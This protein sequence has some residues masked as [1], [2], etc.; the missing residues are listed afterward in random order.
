MVNKDFP[1]KAAIITKDSVITYHQLG[2]H[3]HQ[4]SQFIG[5]REIK[6]IAIFSEN[7]PE[8]IYAFYA[9]WENGCIAVPVDFMAS[10]DD[11]AYIIN[12]C[13]PE[14]IFGSAGTKDSLDKIQQK[15]SYQPEIQI[16]DEVNLPAFTDADHWEGP[17]DR[18]TTAVIIYTSGTTGSPKGVM[19]SF[20]NL[21]AN[22]TA[23]TKEVAI[24][25]P[26]RQV[27]LLLPLH[28]VF[29]LVGSMV[30]PLH[31]GA[32]AV[33]SP[34]MQTADLM[35]TF[36]KNQVAIMIGVP[37]LYELMFKGISTKI[38][39]SIVA[40][41]LFAIVR[42]FHSKK[43]SRK[44]FK[45]VHDGLGGHLEIMVAGGAALNKEVGQFWKDLGFEIL[46]GFGMTEAA[47]M[48]TFTRPGRLRIGS[49]G[50][51][52]PSMRIEIRDGE[53]VAKGPNVMQGYYN[54]PEE[55][56]EVIKDGWLH[57]GDLGYID[58]KG[59]LFITGRKKEIIVLSNGK[60]IN[61]LELEYKLEKASDCIR[62][63]GVFIKNEQL[64]ALIVPNFQLL[65]EKEIKDV[66]AYFRNEVFPPFNQEQSSYKRI[67]QFTIVRDDLPR[68]RLGKMQ[69]FKLAELVEKPKPGAKKVDQ[70]DMPEYLAVKSFLESQVDID[71]APNQHIE[72]DIALDSL[73]KI[74]LIDYIEQTFGV[75]IE[76]KQ[77]IQF[78][79]LKH[80]AEYIRDKKQWIKEG[81]A[82]WS[83]ALKEKVEVKLPKTWFT[84]NILKGFFKGL[85]SIYFKMQS[86][87]V[88]NVP[89]TGPYIIAPNHQS[90]F[91]G[92]FVAILLKRNIMHN[93]YFYAK[94]KHV[95]NFILRF[96]ANT[97]NVIVMDTDRDLK[98]SI[99]KLAEVLKQG[100]N[101]IIFPEGTRT[102]NGAIGEFKKTFAILSTELNVP[103]IPVA[104]D[105][106][107]KAMPQG[108][109]LPKAGTKISVTF[110]PAI[111]PQDHTADT[112]ADAVQAAILETM[113]N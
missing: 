9:A 26:D 86:K 1:N 91:D 50:E 37:R 43:L 102:T 110:L 58:K 51:A 47:P 66:D 85:F 103:V 84:Q 109:K 59:Y 62:E 46:E 99:Q 6:K 12:D 48:I 94:R 16:F 2:G 39:S 15:L 14:I 96:L 55:T 42:R 40:R 64:H 27:L 35:E 38:N 21:D 30:V 4:Y 81:T 41:T 71:I 101:I 68:T 74:S 75:A 107:F 17:S 31:I 32:T 54:R 90:F 92:L 80:M 23:V 49:P 78:P 18:E 76:E 8:W 113:P 105:G 33:M 97:N 24:Y 95:K 98:E 25:N 34:S 106:A 72:F 93:T 87:G 89:E 77:L 13:R 111:L 53:I 29:P 108:S 22:I 73:G 82:N 100:K 67:M 36:K 19:L 10:V 45:K 5:K 112:L 61:P 7:R 88:E 79:S 28:H 3:I 11:V 20:K 69:R 52:L 44:V 83:E 56:A 104:I 65:S 60:N 70:L 57:T 63:A